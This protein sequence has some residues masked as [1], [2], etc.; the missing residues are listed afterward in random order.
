MTDKKATSRRS[1]SSKKSKTG[2]A[3]TSRTTKTKSTTKKTSTTKAKGKSSTGKTSTTKARAKPKTSSAKTSRRRTT[4][5]SPPEAPAKPS[6]RERL[7]QFFQDPEAI[8][9][10]KEQLPSWSD[11][12]GAFALIILGVLTFSSLFNPTGDIAAPLANGLQRAFGAGAY[13]VALMV[14]SMGVVMLLPKAG[15]TVRFNWMRVLSI[16]IALIGLLGLFHL[17]AFDPEPRDLARA[18]GG[19]GYVGWAISNLLTGILGT[20]LALLLLTIFTL[21]FGGMAAGIQRRDIRDAL[22]RFSDQMDDFAARLKA[23]NDYPTSHPIS[24]NVTAAVLSEHPVI[25]TVPLVQPAPVMP[26][27]MAT[28]SATPP[29]HIEV[30]P[31]SQPPRPVVSQDTAASPKPRKR[32]KPKTQ[33]APSIKAKKAVPDP[34]A[35]NNDKDELLAAA[36]EQPVTEP[37]P[38]FTTVIIN[39]QV[40]QA[41]VNNNGNTAAIPREKPTSKTRRRAAHGRRHFVVDGFQDKIKIGRRSKKLPPL[42]S[43]QYTDLKLPDEDEVNTNAAIIETTML[44]FDVEA[45]VIDVR[46]GPSVTQYAVSPIKEVIDEN[47]Q[48][49]IIRTRVSKISA[50]ASD[51]A[52]ALSTKTL[53]IE[54]PVPG[55]SYVGIEVPNREPSIVS[56]RSI[57]ETDSFYEQRKKPLA[58]PLGRDVSGDP[59]IVDLATM[60]HLLI[61]GTTG[62]GKSVCL[63]SFITALVMNNT[64]NRLRLIILDPKMVEFAQFNGL[65]HLMGPV[66]TDTERIIGVLRWATREMDRRYKLLEL[67]KA[68]NIDA[69]NAMLGRRRR[70]EHMSHM[71]IIVDEIG[72][73]MMLRPDETEKTLTRLA[74]KARAAGMH[75]VVATQRPSV[76]V[77][78]GLIKANFPARISFAVAAGVD[79]RVIL[80]TVGSETLIGKGDML[81]LGPDAAGPKRLQGCFLT[82]GEIDAVVA[83]WKEW[84]AQMIEDGRMEA[85]GMPPWEQALTRYESLSQ[86]DP[87]LE[88]ALNLVVIEGKASVS[89]IQRRLGVGYPRAASIM[90]SLHELGIIGKPKAGGR[91][92]EVLVKSV[93]QARRMVHNNRRK[94]LS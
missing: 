33:P 57:L 23:R 75:L 27:E 11:E 58:I 14:I 50:L 72:D 84:H 47:G 37:E 52:L 28:P 93:E 18:G 48:Q 73:L 19:G 25:E 5:K 13:L 94:R 45:D 15:I 62:S 43:L 81:F 7:R 54:A 89:L 70:S 29:P 20:F 71:V 56:L 83:H 21:F 1:S 35:T 91:T 3:S 41:P 78:T 4:R 74:Q 2:H 30:T 66:E 59:V 24:E 12:V 64:P 61:A 36:N 34:I 69:Y 39:G 79:S 16:E 51:L 80:D 86:M 9:R 49:A 87:V 76:D 26:Q 68:R 17:L 44:E 53:R 38:Q 90:D 31:Q 77:I 6:R 92:R 65:P 22:S 55:H 85:R 88:D 67:E 40:V 46:V 10:L 63:R 60:P 42:D 82:D 8:G 32:R